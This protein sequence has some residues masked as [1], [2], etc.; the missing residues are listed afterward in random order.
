METIVKTS[1]NEYKINTGY[2]L[3]DNVKKYLPECFKN[4][5]IAVITDDTVERLYLDKLLSQ[6]EN[7]VSFVVKHGEKSK[8]FVNAE[9]ICNFLAK[10]GFTR[11]DCAIALGGG[12]IGDLTGFAAAIYMRGIPYLQMPTTLL[13]GIDSSVG[14]KTAVNISYGKNLAGR[15]YPPVGVIFDLN[16]L[17][18]LPEKFIR[19]GIGE[20][21]K[22][23]LL[24]GNGLFNIME[25]GL[26]KDN[27]EEFVDACINC[28]KKIVEADENENSLRRLLN[29]GHTVGHAVE[30]RSNLDITHGVCVSIGLRDICRASLNAGYLDKAAYEKITA[31]FDKYSV[32]RNPYETK[33][34]TDSI[35]VDKKTENDVVNF[36]TVHGIGDCRI[37][38]VK[39]TGLENFLK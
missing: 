15:I 32:P 37:T 20:G 27:L 29:L 9:A 1:T 7:A 38:P 22:Y 23:A 30:R 6:L 2:G 34:L 39:I 21:L 3:L 26:S 11:K 4:R 31:L 25:R 17:S 18:T 10:N 24:E 13:A 28:K 36:V 14:G 19:D 12:V 35:K 33:E 5:K 16:A 8:S